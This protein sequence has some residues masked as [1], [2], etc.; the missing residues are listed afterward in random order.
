MCVCTKAAVTLRHSSRFPPLPEFV[1][2][3]ANLY[4]VLTPR[5]QSSWNHFFPHLFYF[6]VIHVRLFRLWRCLLWPNTLTALSPVIKR[7]LHSNL[8]EDMIEMNEH[9]YFFTTLQL[10]LAV[11][12]K[13]SPYTSWAWWVSPDTICHLKKACPMQQTS[14]FTTL[15]WSPLVGWWDEDAGDGRG[16][17]SPSSAPALPSLVSRAA[18]PAGVAAGLWERSLA[19]M[20]ALVVWCGWLMK[21][22]VVCY[23]VAKVTR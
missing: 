10:F 8:P 20:G 15:S 7:S 11:G 19:R 21:A 12:E 18:A 1:M 2:L 17:W 13:K 14:A 6:A 9:S 5:F 3:L 22:W 23:V 16:C 4:T